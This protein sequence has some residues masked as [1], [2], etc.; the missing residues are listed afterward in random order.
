[1]W[2][3]L[4]APSPGHTGR[5]PIRTPL[6]VHLPT[7]LCIA[8]GSVIVSELNAAAGANLVRWRWA[9]P[10]SKPKIESTYGAKVFAVYGFHGETPGC[11]FQ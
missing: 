6:G 5:D 9:V 1:M 3:C 7:P 11:A 4:A 10:R 8:T 2:R